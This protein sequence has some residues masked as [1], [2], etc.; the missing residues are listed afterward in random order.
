VTVAGVSIH[1]PLAPRLQRRRTYSASFFRGDYFILRHLTSFL[2]DRLPLHIRAGDLVLDV[3]CGEQPL[4]GLV[5]ALGARYV[6]VDI[7]QNA[8]GTVDHVC[9][10]T[11]LP[12]DDAGANAVVCTEVLEHVSETGRAFDELA[13]VLAPGGRMLVTVPFA[14]PLH[15]EPDDF[16]RLTTYQI[17]ACAAARGLEVVELRSA[18]NEL[19]VIATVVDNLW[20]RMHPGGGS[21]FWRAVGLAS[22]VVL[23]PLTLALST[24]VGRWLPARYYLSTLAVLRK[25]G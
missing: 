14:Y 22:R 2:H 11:Q 5:E 17:R 12:L 23:N 8:Q 6:G 21:L 3:G 19:E 24:V 10:V 18:G 15:E 4:R 7:T 25:P 9:S 16:V 13:R 20:N 1:P